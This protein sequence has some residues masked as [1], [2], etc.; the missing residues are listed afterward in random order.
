MCWDCGCG[1]LE[2][3]H[4]DPR[5]LVTMDLQGA[6]DANE[7]S[8]PTVVSNLVMSLS[9][10]NPKLAKEIGAA[11][12]PYAALQVVKSRAEQ[13]FTLGVAY[14]AM[15]ADKSVAADGHRDFVSPEVLEKTAHEWLV[16]NRDVNLFHSAKS[17]FQ[18]HFTPAESYIWRAPDWQV[19]SPVDGKPYVV[20]A[21]DWLLGGY[22]DEFGWELVKAE[23]VNGWS[24]EGAA[25]RATPSPERLALVEV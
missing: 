4:D 21:G 12:T 13:R 9:H 23:L 5:H 10:F 25:A 8:I 11:Q 18:G 15:K 3:A 20:K 6:S 19:S 22:W 17:E 2:N 7:T 1:L 16:K 14:P 24:P